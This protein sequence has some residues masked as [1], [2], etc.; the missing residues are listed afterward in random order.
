[1]FKRL[2]I[3]MSDPIC[4]CDEQNLSWI[5]SSDSKGANLIIKCKSCS[6]QLIVSH[7][8]YVAGWSFE[9]P[10]PGKK[11]EEKPKPKLDVLEGGK[12][13]PIGPLGDPT[14]VEP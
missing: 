4:N 3:E 14:A 11:K 1:M 7:E 6:T 13:I 9:R 10:Y 12:V 2:V 8:K 5:P